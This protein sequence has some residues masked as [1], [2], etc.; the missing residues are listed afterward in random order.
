[1][2]NN[3]SGQFSYSTSP[4]IVTVHMR[5]CLP[6]FCSVISIREKPLSFFSSSFALIK[7]DSFLLNYFKLKVIF[8]MHQVYTWFRC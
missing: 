1:M 5:L 6:F 4:G 8:L 7:T 3:F 2:K